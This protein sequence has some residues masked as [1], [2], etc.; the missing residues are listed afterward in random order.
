MP[1]IVDHDTRRYEVADAAIRVISRSGLAGATIRRI[2]DEAGYSTGVVSHYF[3]EKEDIL[4]TVLR[5]T[6][7][8]FRDRVERL[9]ADGLDGARGAILEMLPLDAKRLRQ[10]EVWIAYFGES[11][12]SRRLSREKLKRYHDLR[13][14]LE[15]ALAQ[16]VDRGE[17]R[18]D[19]NIENE[20]EWL[21]AI[22]EGL[23]MQVLFD[24]RRWPPARQVEFLDH[25]LALLRP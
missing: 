20:A 5:Q 10:W 13:E 17:V 3:A 19:I 23:S 21:I 25:H 12:G 14:L 8:Q 11:I 18:S 15:V 16:A 6:V 1:K 22:G 4:L 7:R 2:A 9:G 24:K